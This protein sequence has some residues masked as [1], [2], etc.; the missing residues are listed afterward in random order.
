[1]AVVKISAIYEFF[2]TDNASTLI[3]KGE[4][5]EESNRVLNHTYDS[6]LGVIKGQVQASQKQQRYSVEV[7]S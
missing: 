5:S 3:K 4:K 1:M 2:K 6:T 7:S